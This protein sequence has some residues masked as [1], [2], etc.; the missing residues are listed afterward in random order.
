MGWWMMQ[1]LPPPS[2]PGSRLT[3]AKWWLTSGCRPDRMQ[4][5]RMQLRL[6]QKQPHGLQWT[7]ASVNGRPRCD[8][9]QK[10]A[11][12]QLSSFL[13]DGSLLCGAYQHGR[14]SQWENGCGA[15]HRCAVLLQSGRVCGGRHTAQSCRDKRY[16][17]VE[18]GST[19]AEAPA[20]PSRAAV[21]PKV[22]IISP[23][24]GSLR[25]EILPR[26]IGHSGGWSLLS[27]KYRGN[28]LDPFLPNGLIYG[29]QFMGLE[30]IL[31]ETK[32][33]PILQNSSKLYHP[34][35]FDIW[36]VFSTVGALEIFQ[37]QSHHQKNPI[38]NM[39]QKSQMI[40]RLC[41]LKKEG[42]VCLKWDPFI[43]RDSECGMNQ[44]RKD[45]HG[46]KI[47]L[48]CQL[49]SL[50]RWCE[51]CCGGSESRAGVETS[52]KLWDWN[53]VPEVTL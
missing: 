13:K 35:Q 44:I 9:R 52:W 6:T 34:S 10:G 42:R 39:V 45:L 4:V 21:A 41:F 24:V 36:W 3:S 2:V 27:L 11:H 15:G 29:G 43:E 28:V 7:S 19:T 33:G 26:Y 23:L 38:F 5:M 20:K 50:F 8:R 25:D 16:R 53:E 32:W 48:I 37:C 12:R 1:P 14:C 17:P 22:G 49:F 18:D 51:S 46:H 40:Q 30:W 31:T 47:V